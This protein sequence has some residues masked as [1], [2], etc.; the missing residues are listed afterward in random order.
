MINRHGYIISKKSIS[1]EELNKT[2]EELYITPSVLEEF[3]KDIQSYPM[4]HENEKDLIIPRY[5]GT[6]KFGEAK[7]N[8]HSIK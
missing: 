2:K 1:L 3:S 8:F 4:Y 6:K 7:L 5:Y